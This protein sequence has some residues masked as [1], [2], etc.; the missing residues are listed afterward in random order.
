MSGKLFIAAAGAGKTRKIIHDSIATDKKVLILT[1]TITNE[2]QI[3]NRFKDKLGI[4]PGN[5]TISTWFSFLLNEGIRPYQGSRF[6]ER[7]EGI[8]FVNGQHITY[9]KK[10]SN[11][12]FAKENKIYTDKLAE[13]VIELNNNSQGKVFER[14]TK[15][16]DRIYIDEVQDM[17]GYDLAVLKNLI[18]THT[19]VIMVGDPRQCTYSTHSPR[20]YKKYSFGKIDEFLKKECKHLDV[21]IDENTLNCTY[22]NND[23]ICSFANKLYPNRTPVTSINK[24]QDEFDGVKI[25]DIEDVDAYLE[26]SKAIQLRDSKKTKVN[27]KYPCYNFGQSKGLEFKRVLIYPTKPMWDWIIDNSKE[28]KDQSKAKFYVAITRAF[29]SAV[30]VRKDKQK[31]NLPMMKL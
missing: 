14:I 21:E 15:M 4:V 23:L 27:T 26:K 20:K 11:D 16:Y 24:A 12:Y 9:E 30:I 25:I 6:K 17:V 10:E 31:C 29:D 28:L 19:D 18:T 7:I 8:I 2:Q 5:I 3:I 13:C 22:R 1:Y